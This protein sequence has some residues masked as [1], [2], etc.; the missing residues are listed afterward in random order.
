MK[1]FRNVPNWWGYRFPHNRKLWL[2]RAF[3]VSG[4]LFLTV[5]APADFLCDA[6]RAQKPGPAPAAVVQPGA[7][8]KPSR[9]LPPSTTGKLPPSTTGKLPPR[10]PAE[11]EFMQGMIMH[12][13]Q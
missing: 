11:V 6:A 3:A 5:S 4:G 7:P 9:K 10:S 2:A 8:G 13:A 1:I 12:H